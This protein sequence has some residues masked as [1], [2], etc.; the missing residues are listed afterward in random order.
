[1]SL[2][3]D[4]Q[5]ECGSSW[6]RLESGVGALGVGLGAVTVNAGG[7]ITAFSGVLR[8][9]E[10]GQQLMVDAIETREALEVERAGDPDERGGGALRLVAP[11]WEAG[12]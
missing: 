5:C 8:C 4:R 10:C 7:R 12:Q 9:F 3:D 1:M 11:P 2:D 6:F